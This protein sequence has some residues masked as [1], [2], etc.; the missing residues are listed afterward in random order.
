MDTT[1]AQY[2]LQIFKHYLPVVWSW[3]FDTHTLVAIPNGLKFHVEGF[4]HKGWVEVVYDEGYDTF[5]VRTLKKDGS[6][7]QEQ[8]DVYLDGLV[9]VIDGMVER[10]DNYKQRVRREYAM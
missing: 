6:I 7:K 8:E 3:G 1:M 10:C 9:T 2:I 4:L 5:T